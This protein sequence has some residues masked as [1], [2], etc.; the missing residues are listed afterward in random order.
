MRRC[1]LGVRFS[2]QVQPWL[3]GLLAAQGE[4]AHH[5]DAHADEDEDPRRYAQPHPPGQVALARVARELVLRPTAATCS[6]QRYAH[7]GH[8]A[9]P[10][11]PQ[12]NTSRGIALIFQDDN[13]ATVL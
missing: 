4:D 5:G 6:H 9:S 3:V 7:R 12:V 8:V 1:R 10:Q 13:Y 2:L 11:N